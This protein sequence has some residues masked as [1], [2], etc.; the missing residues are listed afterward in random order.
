MY[1]FVL[2]RVT[3]YYPEPRGTITATPLAHAGCEADEDGLEQLI[4]SDLVVNF[5]TCV[6]AFDRANKRPLFRNVVPVLVQM[7]FHYDFAQNSSTLK[8]FIDCSCH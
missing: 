5:S 4:A 8:P 2:M 1:S 7:C 6:A 3:D